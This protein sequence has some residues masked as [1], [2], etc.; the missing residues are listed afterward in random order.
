M[1]F[2]EYANNPRKSRAIILIVVGIILGLI[3][4]YK[5]SIVV[6]A[7]EA[8]VLF[9]TFGK[10]V[11]TDRTYGEGFHVIAP[12]NKMVVY[13]V[14]QQEIMEKMAVLSSNGLDIIVEASVWFQ[15]VYKNLGF[16]HQEKGIRYTDNVV[17]PA[18]RSVTRSVI[19]R[20]TP[21][22]IYSSKRD[23]IQMEIFERGKKGS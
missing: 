7:G 21:D 19:G 9:K 10:G 18:I 17:K 8:G 2:Q 14:R 5:S 1:D 20:Y 23:A 3:I 15:P 13:E 16:L 4:L 12:W 6:K 22:E 11:V